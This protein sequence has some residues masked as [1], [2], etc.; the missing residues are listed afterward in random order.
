M[1]CEGL[2]AELVGFERSGVI[3][4]FR[5][6]PPQTEGRRNAHPKILGTW[7]LG[8]LIATAQGQ[9]Q[10]VAGAHVGH[11]PGLYS[12]TTPTIKYGVL[13]ESRGARR[14]TAFAHSPTR[15]LG[16]STGADS[17]LMSLHPSKPRVKSLLRSKDL[18]S[19]SLLKT[20][21]CRRPRRAARAACDS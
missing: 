8:V 7:A 21:H 20:A 9:N 17:R 10:N 6:A 15:A 18:C 2:G 16:T 19:F 3:M 12:P 14:Y 11:P 5:K 4:F 1:F 13:W